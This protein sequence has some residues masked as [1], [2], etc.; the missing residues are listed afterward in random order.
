MAL[1]SCAGV[2]SVKVTAI[3][4]G[5]DV[6][7]DVPLDLASRVGD[8]PEIGR[9]DALGE[10]PQGPGRIAGLVRGPV[11]GAVLQFDRID[12]QVDGPGAAVDGDDVA[13][14]H[15]ADRPALLC[16]RPDVADAQPAGG[17]GEAAVG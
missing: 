7:V 1:K 8:G 12:L 6:G 9:A 5:L 11:A 2:L 10:L 4:P 17:A 14:L 15:Q 3:L 13:V 16:F